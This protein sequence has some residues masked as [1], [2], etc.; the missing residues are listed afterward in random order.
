MKEITIYFP[1]TYLAPSGLSILSACFGQV[2]VCRPSNRDLP[3]SMQ[4]AV[5]QGRLLVFT[6]VDAEN[7]RLN[8]LMDAYYAWA[9]ENNGVDLAFYKGRDSHIPFFEDTSVSNIRQSI[10]DMDPGEAVGEDAANPVLEARLFLEMAQ[11]HDCQNKELEQSLAQVRGKE[12]DM[13]VD[14][15]GDSDSHPDIG[16]VSPFIPAGDPGAYLTAR[17]LQAWGRLF[18]AGSV[19]GRILVTDSQAVMEHLVEK[20]PALEE[21]EE[22]IALPLPSSDDKT[23][24][25]W[26]GRLKEYLFQLIEKPEADRPPELPVAEQGAP[27]LRLTLFRWARADAGALFDHQMEPPEAGAAPDSGRNL[28]ICYV[29]VEDGSF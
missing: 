20:Q 15:L 24:E 10:R 1:M 4:A 5:D 23:T 22:T 11:A 25:D 16:K 18:Q 21:L 28:L 14:L 29:A 2:A 8:E 13:L 6:P 27:A 17:R 19:P 7:D 12:K 3:E 9:R 26:Q